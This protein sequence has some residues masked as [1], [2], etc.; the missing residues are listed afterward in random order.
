[1]FGEIVRSARI[2][3]GWTASD[4]IGKMNNPFSGAYLSKIELHNEIPNPLLICELADILDIDID[5]LL[6]CA[7]K[8]KVNQYSQS[9]ERKYRGEY[10]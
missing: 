9:I 1:M 10:V 2:N 7:K 4:L 3:K 6:E 5:F 8:V